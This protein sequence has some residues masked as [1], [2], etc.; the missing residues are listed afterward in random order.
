M[1]KSTYGIEKSKWTR[2]LVAGWEVQHS[3]QRR[4][5]EEGNAEGKMIGY[6]TS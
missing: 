5:F 3:R 6:K 4:T 1:K 2:F